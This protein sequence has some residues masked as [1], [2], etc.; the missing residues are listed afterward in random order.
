MPILSDLNLYDV[1]ILVRLTLY[2]M[3]TVFG[4]PMKTSDLF[5]AALENEG[6]EY[7]FALPGN[8]CVMRTAHC[9]HSSTSLRRKCIGWH[10]HWEVKAV[11]AKC[12]LN[13]TD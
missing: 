5:V 8:T 13:P 1:V 9:M 11:F 6:V 4:K 2:R 12:I 10:V 3:A 7:I